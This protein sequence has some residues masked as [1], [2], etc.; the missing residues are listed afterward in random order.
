MQIKHPLCPF[1]RAT[2]VVKN[3][4]KKS[5]A[6]N[7]LCRRCGKQFLSDYLYWG[8]NPL[9]KQLILRH[10]LRGCGVRDTAHLVGV[11]VYTVLTTLNKTAFGFRFS[12]RFSHYHKVQIDEQWSYVGGKNNKCWMFYAICAQSGE[13]LGAAWG[14]RTRKTLKI[15]LNQLQSLE[16][17]FYCTDL[18][19]P[20]TKVFAP[21]KHLRGKEYTKKIEGTNTW[22]RARISRLKRRTTTFS[23]KEQNHTDHIKILFQQRNQFY[24]SF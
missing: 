21:E 6:Q 15:L 12:P 14:K 5:G 4:R 10:L 9:T 22:C 19:R 16:I 18:W 17:D 24:H 1:C 13:I 20:F 7:Y 23:K 11:S 2:K 3:G 8:A